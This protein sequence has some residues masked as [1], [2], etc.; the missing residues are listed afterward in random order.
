MYSFL[1]R[2]LLLSFMAFFVKPDKP[3]DILPEIDATSEDSLNTLYNNDDNNQ[4]EKIMTT[5]DVSGL[6]AGISTNVDDASQHA[7]PAFPSLEQPDNN[8]NP[9]HTVADGDSLFDP[10][11]WGIQG[12]QWGAARIGDGWNLGGVLVNGVVLYFSTSRPRKGR[13]TMAISK[14][15]LEVLQK[16]ECRPDQFKV[17]KLRKRDQAYEHTWQIGS[18]W[19]I[20]ERLL[21]S[22]SLSIPKLRAVICYCCDR[23]EAADLGYTGFGCT[24]IFFV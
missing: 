20:V 23:L 12:I 1:I 13:G 9:P 6:K 22:E 8:G 11:S 2:F 5:P 7:N 3:N 10:V 14:A 17:C 18:F 21:D 24:V 15:D 16:V 4:L 19:A